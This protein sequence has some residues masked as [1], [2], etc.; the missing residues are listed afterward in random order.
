MSSLITTGDQPDFLAMCGAVAKSGLGGIRTPEQ[1]FAMAAQALADDPQGADSPMA[2][3]RALGRAQRDFHLINGKPSMKAE[4]MLARFQGAGGKVRWGEYSDKRCEATFSHPQGGDVTIDWTL[5][6]ARQAGLIKA[7][8]WTTHPR[9]MLRSRVISEAIRTVFPGILSGAYTPDEVD[10]I[11]APA[12]QPATVVI[13]ADGD[14]TKARSLY[15]KVAAADAQA[16][17]DLHAQHPTAAA[18]CTAAEAWLA[19]REPIVIE[20]PQTQE[21][22]P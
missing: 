1:A 21:S 9:A 10:E 15:L 19:D 8:P 7:G 17:K 3:L 12:Q 5:E 2:F 18:F 22:A 16:A 4:T 13:A 6:R 11:S 20:E 14:K